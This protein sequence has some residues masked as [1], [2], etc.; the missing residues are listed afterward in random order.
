MKKMLSQNIKKMLATQTVYSWCIHCIM[1]T[2]T[3]TIWTS[4]FVHG[5]LQQLLWVMEAWGLSKIKRSVVQNYVKI[6]KNNLEIIKWSPHNK[7]NLRKQISP[8]NK[9]YLKMMK[10]T[11]RKQIFHFHYLKIAFIILRLFSFSCFL[12]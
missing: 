12:F 5:Q 7:N 8:D 3:Q 4:F 9:N 1:N 6:V 10:L 11:L 2:E